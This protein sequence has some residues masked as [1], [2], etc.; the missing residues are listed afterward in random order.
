M[1]SEGLK[2]GSSGPQTQAQGF[3]QGGIIVSLLEYH[4][5]HLVCTCKTCC[6]RCS[7]FMFPNA[8]FSRTPD[9]PSQCEGL[10][11]S[12]LEELLLFSC[13]AS[14][15]NF[16]P[17]RSFV[18][19]QRWQVL[20]SG[21]ERWYGNVSSTVHSSPAGLTLLLWMLMCD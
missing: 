4:H 5:M 12:D 2:F 1:L 7:W 11:H 18:N 16:Y 6:R 8:R 3:V 21:E 14:S 19:V 20:E 10:K 15:W 17:L 13:L 9:E